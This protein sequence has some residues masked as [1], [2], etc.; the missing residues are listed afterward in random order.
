MTDAE[1]SG[2][3]AGQLVPIVWQ[4]RKV[5]AFVPALL[6]ERF[7]GGE[8]PLLR[9]AT[10]RRTEQAANL[11]TQA[12]VGL[13]A[14]WEPITRLLSRSEGIASSFF[15]GITS[16]AT[17]VAL[18][19][20]KLG[21]TPAAVA[22]AENVT[23]LTH[24]LSQP[25]KKLTVGMLHEWHRILLA[26]AN[27]LPSAMV[28]AFRTQQGWIGGSTPLDAALVTAPPKY[29]RALMND[30]VGFVNDR[31]LDPVTQAAIAHAQFE[32][33][34]PY[35]DGNGRVG[36]VLVSWILASRLQLRVAP[37]FSVYVSRDR[38]GYL[39]GLVMFQQD[40]VDAWVRWFADTVAR[41]AT[42]AIDV[43]KRV[44]ALLAAWE[45]RL[46]HLRS[47]AAARQ[48]LALFPERFVVTA[49]DVVQA[50]GVSDRAARSALT[51]LERLGITK[52]L[53]VTTGAVGRPQKIW[54]APELAAEVVRL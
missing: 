18:A 45:S 30:L 51:E 32:S 27:Y 9:D 33:I 37:P 3:R 14:N 34:H 41:A 43:T 44:S 17:D 22:V 29:L 7:L 15:E 52:E 42:S 48:V 28:G 53:D 20:S 47:D 49:N 25:G 21:G 23:A 2:E 13:P 26:H 40:H 31:S 12:S 16:P 54:I 6:R 50:T 10:I 39:S 38:G 19:V 35:G 8:A 11:A 24:A 4:G 1:G 5:N 46:V 36:R